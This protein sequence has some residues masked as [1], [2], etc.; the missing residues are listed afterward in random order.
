M[1]IINSIYGEL[2]KEFGM[3]DGQYGA[4]AGG[5]SR[6]AYFINGRNVITFYANGNIQGKENI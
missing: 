4:G 3:G 1:G 2:F 5:G 6:V